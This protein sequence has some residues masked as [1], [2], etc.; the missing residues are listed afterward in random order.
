MLEKTSQDHAAQVESN[1]VPMVHVPILLVNYRQYPD[2]W[3]DKIFVS[4]S[5]KYPRGADWDHLSARD[6]Q[7]ACNELLV[8]AISK[9]IS[10]QSRMSSFTTFKCQTFCQKTFAKASVNHLL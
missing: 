10:T 7:L 1:V 4:V 9:N 2:I 8:R 5:E 6:N 3:A